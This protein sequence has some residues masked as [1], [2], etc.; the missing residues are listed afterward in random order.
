MF[1]TNVPSDTGV[2][3]I[4]GLPFQDGGGGGYREPSFLAANH[5]GA[6]T[7]VISGA[8]HGSGTKIRIRK[9]GNQDLNGSDIGSTFWMHGHITYMST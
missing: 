9:N 1:A 2:I 3:D 4:A 7:Y 5:G 8:M 6:G